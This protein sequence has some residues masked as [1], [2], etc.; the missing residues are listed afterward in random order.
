MKSQIKSTKFT[1]LIK[2]LKGFFCKKRKNH[3]HVKSTIDEE[4]TNESDFFRT[5]KK[6]MILS[7]KKE[8]VINYFKKS[9]S[10]RTKIE[11]RS[12]AEYLCLNKKNVF[13]NNIKKFGIYKLY[14]VIQ[15]LNIEFYKKDELIFQYKEPTNKLSIIL[16]GK[17]SLY[18]P[19]FHKKLISIKDFLDYFFFLK[20]NFPK[21]FNLIEHKN[22]NL[23]EFMQKLQLSNYDINVLYDI[24]KET[25]KEFYVEE[26]QKVCEISEGNS[27]GEIALLYNLSQNYNIIAET[28]VYLLTMNRS[29][30]MK[31]MRII[32]ENE[33]LYK[34]FVKLRKYSFLFSSWSNFSLGQIM[35]YF[36]PIKLIKKEIL[37]KQKDFSDSFY[38]IHEGSFDVYCELSL[39]DFSKY[40]NYVLKNNK[41]VLDWIKEEKERNKINIDKIIEHINQMKE[42]N[43]Y[44]KIKDDIDKNLSYIKR[45]MLEQDEEDSQQL[46]NIKLNEDI[47]TEKNT[48]IKIKLFT[49]HKNDFIGVCDSLELKSRFYTVECSSDKGVLSK[50]RILDFIIFIA[51]NHGLDLQNIYEYIHE[52]KK[53]LVERVYKNLDIH[54]NNN[55]RIIRNVYLLA[56]SAFDKRGMKMYKENEYSIKNMKNKYID[57]EG[58]NHLIDRIRQSIN[59]K[60]KIYSL[61]QSE[62]NNNINTKSFQKPKQN[63]E[64]IKNNNFI[65]LKSNINHKTEKGNSKVKLKLGQKKD[66]LTNKRAHTQT[67]LSSNNSSLLSNKNQKLFKPKQVQ[68]NINKDL[69]SNNSI[70]FLKDKT[71]IIDKEENYRSKNH[72]KSISPI[73]YDKKFE[74]I[75]YR[76][77]SYDNKLEQYLTNSLGIYN[78]KRE[79]SQ[80]KILEYKGIIKTK[81]R[82]KNFDRKKLMFSNHFN[83]YTK[84]R[85][86]LLSA[87]TTLTNYRIKKKKKNDFM[88]LVKYLDKSK[89]NE[90]YKN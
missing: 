16:E 76:D 29:D 24:N 58:N 17:I 15:V 38:I 45:K 90:I 10:L 42:V 46:I 34:E 19:Y 65:K 69:N 64:I 32:I 25:K 1:S 33:I 48:K 2:N 37:F 3:H 9:H 47:L 30:F 7:L 61:T 88:S 28:D 56:F 74:L 8:Y 54:L 85:P 77:L 43:K 86:R 60:K 59:H 57:S 36:I 4:N 70:Y 73:V 83:E 20:K 81:N 66:I 13:I 53:G 62:N 31:I 44:P 78:T 39:S 55:K 12:V 80:R 71:S 52:K 82:I 40:K 41:N 87:Y 89:R 35:N 84:K 63:G 68:T 75:K 5:L 18:L 72:N 22:Q 23:F 51:S 6:L 21:T 27:F 11:T 14:S 26:S 50:I 67:N 79:K 49:L